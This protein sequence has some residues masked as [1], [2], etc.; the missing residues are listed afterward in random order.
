MT[1]LDSLTLPEALIKTI[2]HFDPQFWSDLSKVHDPRDPT[3]II[4]RAELELFVGIL[5][6]MLRTGARRNIKYKLGTQAFVD[7]LRGLWETF[8]P[9]ILRAYPFPER[10]FHGDTLH[11]LLKRIE[12]MDLHEHLR[13]PLIKRLLRKRCLE[14]FRLQGHWYEIAVD[15]TG[16]R[17]FHKRHCKHCLKRK[18]EHGT[19][20]LHQV[21]EAKLVLPGL[22]M[23]L[24]VGTEFIENENEDVS[25]QDCEWKAF[26][27]LAKRLKGDFPQL[28]ICL[29]IDGLYLSKPMIDVCQR[30]RWHYFITFKE[31][32]ASALFEEYEALLKLAPEN[33]LREQRGDAVANYRWINDIDWDDR[34][35]HVLENRERTAKGEK[36]FVWA[37]DFRVD[38]ENV[39][40]LE[41]NG[42]RSRWIIEN[43]GFN[44]QKNG[45][46]G[47]EH[48]FSNNNT[49]MKNFYL[50]TQIAHT[51]NQLMEKGSQLREY[52]ETR[53]GSLKVLSERLWAALTETRI[54]PLRL[55]AVLAQRIQIRFDTS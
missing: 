50:L 41:Q 37:T 12:P 43:Q 10:L 47:L 5:F 49:A 23:A 53:L 51:F 55:R 42:G 21:L 34:V 2:D 29:T 11:Y 8:Y 30:N 27:R 32:S 1:E 16:Y 54:D 7:N 15:G 28:N 38:S 36:R 6:L 9:K 13:K 18:L 45:G 33:A 39:E 17:V 24:S 14:S 4:Y 19:V 44:V 26:Q 35:V 46:Y 25:K 52:I 22:G 48:A 31:G 20:Y 40:D 3:R